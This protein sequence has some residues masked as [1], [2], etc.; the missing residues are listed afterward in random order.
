MIESSL[1]AAAFGD[2]PGRWPLPTAST[3]RQ[4]WL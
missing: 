1:T 4:L 3:P 2:Q